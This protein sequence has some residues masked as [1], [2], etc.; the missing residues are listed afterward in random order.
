[1][2]LM[3]QIDFEGET[4]RVGWI[5]SPKFRPSCPKS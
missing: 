3:V 4:L 2:V 1:M 5:D